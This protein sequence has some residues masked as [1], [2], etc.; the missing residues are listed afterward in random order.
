VL[1]CSDPFMQALWMVAGWAVDLAGPMPPV[2]GVLP[3]K[4]QNG[5]PS[6]QDR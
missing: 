1:S 3:A 5:P 4:G 2:P 6:Q